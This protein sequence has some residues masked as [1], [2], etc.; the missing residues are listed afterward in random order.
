VSER[1]ALLA[2][3]IRANPKF[4]IAS[5]I[6]GNYGHMGATL[7]DAVLQAGVKYETVVRP[8]VRRLLAEFPEA[9]TT[10]AFADLLR[11]AGAEQLLMW[12]GKRKVV[13]LNALITL[14]LSDRVETEDDFR[15]WINMPGNLNR[16]RQINGIKDKTAHYLEI[17]LGIQS[18]AVDRHLF[19][20]LAE[21]GLHTRD[22]SEAHMLIREAA[23]SLGIRPS[24]LDHSIWRYMSERKACDG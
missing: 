24:Y 17:L 16:L 8:R 1:G 2:E 9:R 5:S 19:A 18:V 6:D 22:Y 23:E 10:S 15:A 3:Y 12:K 13:T 21:A 4:E 7:T 11:S 20:F 14:L